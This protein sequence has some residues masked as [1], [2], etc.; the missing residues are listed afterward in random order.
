MGN[1][2]VASYRLVYFQPDPEDGERV[3]IALLFQANG[4]V[5]LL[6]NTDF[7]R[8]RCLAPST[9]PNLVQMYLDDLADRLRHD[10]LNVDAIIRRHAPQIMTSEPRKVAWPLTDAARLYL[11][12]RFLHK[13]KV[14]AT[15]PRLEKQDQV[16]A[17]IKQLIHHTVKG[18]KLELHEDAA[19][20]WVLG[21]HMPEIEQVALAMRKRKGVLLI[22][23]V[24]LTIL[25][26]KSALSRINRVT[27][28]FWQYGRLRE[29]EFEPREIRRIGVV[30]NGHVKPTPEYQ[31]AHDFA[32][33][34]FHKEADL[35]VDTTSLRNLGEF[36]R[37]FDEPD[38]T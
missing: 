4:G 5:D 10:Q 33:H 1:Q 20:D 30:L 9:D 26:P 32:L 18:R 12:K 24:D 3:S 38:S 25:R 14:A 8:L 28:T 6:Y 23:G 11:M 22:D 7:P 17:H 34:Q 21:R 15:H 35:V 27:H 29:M 13:E 31:D 37:A 19:A 2:L 16:R 36:E